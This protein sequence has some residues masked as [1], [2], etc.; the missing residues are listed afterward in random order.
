MQNA[1]RSAAPAAFGF[2][3]YWEAITNIVA[4]RRQRAELAQLDADR[5]SDIGITRA[6]AMAEA[7]APLWDFP[8]NW[9]A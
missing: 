9:R 7:R 6:E 4:L 2:S 5:L 8:R 1:I 3:S